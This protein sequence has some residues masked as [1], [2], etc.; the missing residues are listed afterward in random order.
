MPLSREEMSAKRDTKVKA[1]MQELAPIWLVNE[2]YRPREDSL[3]FNLIY[4]NPVYGWV[5]QRMKYDGFNDVLYH[6]GERRVAEAEA[7]EVQ[8]KEPYISGE[9]ATHVPNDPAFRASPPLPLGGI[10]K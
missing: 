8:E 7:L 4:A 9:V 6:M 3:L 10:H 2:D 5:S 1:A